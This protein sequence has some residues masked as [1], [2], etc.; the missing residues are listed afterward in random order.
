MLQEM[1]NDHMRKL[2]G[3]GNVPFLLDVTFNEDA[4]YIITR[5]LVDASHELK[6]CVMM[7]DRRPFWKFIPDYDAERDPRWIMLYGEVIMSESSLSKLCMKIAIDGN[8]KKKDV[9]IGSMITSKV[10]SGMIMRCLE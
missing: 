2:I 10:D 3:Y 9:V 4:S 7:R 8:L 5:A 6:Y 1:N